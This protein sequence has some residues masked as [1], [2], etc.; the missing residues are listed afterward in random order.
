MSLQQEILNGESRTLEY[1]VELP[2]DSE[3]WVK[4]IVAFANGAGGKFVVGVN[5][6]REF[7]GIPKKADLFELKDSIADKISQMCVPQIMFDITAEIVEGAQLLIV[8][9]FPGMATPYYIKSQGKENG[10]YIRLG[11]TTRN[12]DLAALSELENRGRN[13]SYDGLPYRSLK[14]TDAD[15]AFL[16]KDFSK[17][18]KRKITKADL[19]N[20][21]LLTGRSH[22]KAT[23][24]LAILLGEHE[25]TSRIQCARFRGTM[26]ADFLD[27]K[28]YD[29]PLCK[30]IDDAY[31]FVL[32]HLNMAIEING[33]VHDEKYELPPKAIRELIINAAIH[34]NY[35]MNSSVQ[36]AVYDD[37][38]E[39]SSPGTL[40]GT[41]TLE[42]ALSGR[43]S[44][45]NKTL[46]RTL[47]KVHVL[48]GWGSGFQRINTLCQEYGVALPEFTEI[49]DMFRVNFYRRQDASVGDKSATNAGI[50]D[51]SVIKSKIGD[52]S[53]INS[54]IGDKSAINSKIGD[55]SAINFKEKIVEYLAEHEEARSREIA[56]VIGLKISRTKD[57]IT[58][59]VE[60][61]KIVSNGA[62]KNRTYSLK[63]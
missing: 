36:V 33:V 49:G 14:V 60:E 44:I 11:A 7:I 24:A 15:I 26:R 41:L 13:V 53:A 16:C 29:G 19:E 28:D 46:A 58:E 32:N 30:Q 17:R 12:A 43:S 31:K 50:G 27:K 63:K 54:K 47:E 2:E 3:K 39:I 59:L 5:N 40:Y 45:R 23:N 62:N 48:E 8:Q 4:S 22:D 51:K 61:G 35:Q 34:R 38:V 25:Y 52:K 42:E 10:T 1:K 56:D 37:R 18:A 55:K 6:R 9:V 57:Y 20:L 21:H